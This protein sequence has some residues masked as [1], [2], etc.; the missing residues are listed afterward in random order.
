MAEQD[1]LDPAGGSQEPADWKGSFD[2][3]IKDHP[4]LGVF[5]SEDLV[6]V[7]GRW[8]SRMSVSSL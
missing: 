1:N 4:S 3:G 5:K 8:S 7:R 6:E 2:V